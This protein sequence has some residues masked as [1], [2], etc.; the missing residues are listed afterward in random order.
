MIGTTTK[1]GDRTSLS[2]DDRVT[3]ETRVLPTAREWLK[4]PGLQDHGRQTLEYWGENE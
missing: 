4:I 3:L 2:Y 1:R